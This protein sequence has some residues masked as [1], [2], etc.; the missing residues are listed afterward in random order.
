VSDRELA[1]FLATIRGP[2]RMSQEAVEATARDLAAVIAG[3]RE[4][5]ELITRI[6]VRGASGEPI[7]GGIPVTPI[8][9][10]EHCPGFKWIGQPYTTCDGCGKPAWEHEGEMR[11]RD[12]DVFPLDPD[13]WELR[14]WKPG[15]AEAIRRKWEGMTP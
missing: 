1:R 8:P 6:L 5:R 12:R 14:P 13:A 11:L 3:S 9:G 15:E 4:D 10:P 2:K 7:G